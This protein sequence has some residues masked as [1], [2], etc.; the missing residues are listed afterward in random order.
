M[1]IKVMTMVF[2]R[3]PVGGSERLLALAI[4]D[5]AHDDGTHI[6]PAIDTLASKTMQS[7]STVQRQI[8]KMLAIGWLERV[9]SK[10]GRGYVNEYRISSAWIRGELLPSQVAPPLVTDV[11]PSYPQAGQIDTLISAKKGVIQNEK[12]VIHDVKGVTA[13]TPES[14][15][16]PKNRTPLPPEGG[17]TG[18]DQVFAGYP[19]HANRAK[20]ERRWRRLGP[21]AALQQAMLA[22]IAVQR[23]SVKW[24][25]DKGQFVPEFHTWL[26]NAGWRDDVSERGSV[27]PWDTNRSTIEA[28]AAELGMAPWNEGDLSV[29]RETF[30]V[31][32]ERV[33]RLVEQEAE[34]AST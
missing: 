4:A 6:Y 13:M 26:R 33:R 30:H 8:A 12:G 2:D 28:K 27:V 25:K 19:N 21:D 5:H 11:E 18:F 17:A 22:A 20:A 31:Y 34:C 14:S 1:S 3:Y 15:E 32:T 24:T 10:T 23:H 7:R 9:G 29:N 16:P